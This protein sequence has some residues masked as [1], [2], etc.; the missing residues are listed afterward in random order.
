[1]RVEPKAGADENAWK[2]RAVM[3]GLYDV[4]AKA[5]PVQAGHTLGEIGDDEYHVVDLGRQGLRPGMYFYVAPARN[6]G[7]EAVYVDR[8]VL[9]REKGAAGR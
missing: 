4:A 6:A 8:V 1:V 7:V 2:S 5:S 3:Y 9:V